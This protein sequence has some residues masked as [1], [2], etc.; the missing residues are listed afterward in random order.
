MSCA[1]H[2]LST[3][4]GAASLIGH[5]AAL[6]IPH[7]PTLT[8]PEATFSGDHRVSSRREPAAQLHPETTRR[9]RPVLVERCMAPGL[10][11]CSRQVQVPHGA[12]T[13]LQAAVQARRPSSL[14][15]A[16]V[17]RPGHARLGCCLSWQQG[18][19]PQGVCAPRR[20]HIR[21]VRSWPCRSRSAGTSAV[22][23]VDHRLTGTIPREKYAQSMTR[24]TKNEATWTCEDNPHA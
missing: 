1:G 3:D 11:P 15:C 16:K 13:P 19:R 22:D 9:A 8:R 14:S 21:Q 20:T 6:G 18:S 4:H 12:A 10:N 5:L 17:E 23:V 7:R 24:E 2:G